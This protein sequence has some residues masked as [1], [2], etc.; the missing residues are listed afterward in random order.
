MV[1]LKDM[2]RLK[3]YI[4]SSCQTRQIIG[5]IFDDYKFPRRKLCF[6]ENKDAEEVKKA[7]F[8]NKFRRSH[9]VRL[10]VG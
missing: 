9:S 8:E 10:G 1:F 7:D 6:F 3:Y 5:R 2:K 4:D